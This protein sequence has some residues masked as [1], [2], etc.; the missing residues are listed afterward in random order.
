MT[1]AGR[2]ARILRMERINAT[3]SE[4]GI[5]F[6]FFARHYEDFI[7]GKLIEEEVVKV[8]ETPVELV[9][10]NIGIFELRSDKKLEVLGRYSRG[11][12]SV[13][14]NTPIVDKEE[15]LSDPYEFAITKDNWAQF[16]T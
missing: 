12:R 6:P 7:E 5:K 1:K 3:R 14:V 4:H 9:I 2:H 16:T 8:D 13:R 10:P 11:G 15:V